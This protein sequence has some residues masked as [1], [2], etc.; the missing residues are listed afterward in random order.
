MAARHHRD[1]VQRVA[2]IGL[3]H[4]DGLR[5]LFDATPDLPS[6]AWDLTGGP[7]P[8]EIWLT[9][10]HVGH[11]LGLAFLGREA[12]NVL[13][14]S[15]RA[16]EAVLAYLAANEPYATLLRER[17]LV[18]RPIVPG[19]AVQLA[20]GLRVTPL[21]VP[22]RNEQADTVA[23]RL[24]GP[25]A[26]ALYCPDIDSWS[27]WEYDL[28]ELADTLDLLLVDGTFASVDELPAG[29]REG[30][31]HPLVSDT[32]AR[33]AGRR[34]RLQLIH[35]NHTNPLHEGQAADVARDGDLHEL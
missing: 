4:C 16:T 17:R 33:V 15:L 5:L 29:R 20:G 11:I 18:P 9:H 19:L 3:Q 26:A 6:Q 23:F 35:L 25:R 34:A 27:T 24:D 12:W 7:P 30:V 31:P 1:R 21:W 2:A 10:A 28:G 32:R 22:H 14:V 8:A 13:D